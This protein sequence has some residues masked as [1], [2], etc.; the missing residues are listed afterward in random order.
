MSA[1]AYEVD[2]TNFRE[3]VLEASHRVLVLVDFWAEW[4]QPC[5]ILKPILEQLAA[6]YA[7]RFILAKVNSDLNQELAAQ[8]AVRGIPAVKAFVDG[9]IVDEFTGAL[10]AAQVREFIETLLPS[11]AEPV[12]R[13]AVDA[14]SQGQ[15]ERARTLFAEA[16]VIDPIYEAAK[17]DYVEVSIDTGAIDDARAVLEA[18]PSQR[19]RDELKVEALRARLDL[20]SAS[21]GAS[22]DALASR[23]SAQPD[24]LEVRWQLANACAVDRDYRTAL[25]EL[26]EIVRR[27][28]QWRDGTGRKTMLTLFNLLA[29]Q[30]EYDDLVREYRVAL[31]RVL[32]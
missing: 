14:Y 11:V 8:F 22:R 6:E 23:L 30:P 15:K 10:P 1:H 31:A 9:R 29:P 27:D 26:L 3:Q 24:D 16:M 25:A 20:I 5:R 13:Q 19:I 4:C 7:G 2:A 18:L 32:H 17:L 28:R 21:R 12:Y